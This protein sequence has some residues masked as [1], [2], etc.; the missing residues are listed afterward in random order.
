M[1]CTQC[2]NNEFYKLDRE[3]RYLI[4][5]NQY[6]YGF[7][8]TASM[9]RVNH[10]LDVFACSKCG[11]LEWFN[12]FPGQKYEDLLSKIKVLEG[13][14]KVIEPKIS[15]NNAEIQKI[16]LS[17]KDLEIKQNDRYNL[18]GKEIQEVREKITNLKK[19]RDNIFNEGIRGSVNVSLYRGNQRM[20]LI[21]ENDDIKEEINKDWN[22]YTLLDL[23]KGLLSHIAELQG[24]LKQL[25]VEKIKR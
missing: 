24:D 1:K 19:S 20:L 6:Q 10:W 8:K 3:N 11:H 7:K 2:G 17:I 18:S 4:N 14:L 15:K 16:E 13:Y 22:H 21:N 5:E 12:K 25:N 9:D 23:Q